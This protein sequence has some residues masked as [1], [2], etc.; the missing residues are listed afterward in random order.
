MNTG[1]RAASGAMIAS[2]DDDA[3]PEPD[4]LD[5]AIAG[6][7]RFNC[8]YVG[9]KVLPIWGGPVPEWLPNRPGMLWS[10]V[11][12]LDFGP[13]AAEFGRDG[14]TW[15]L[16]IN[17]LARREAFQRVGPYDNRLGRTAGTLRNQAQREWHLR[18]RQSGLRGFYVPDMVVHHVVPAERLQKRYF[19]RWLYW[20]GIS[21]AILY[22]I[23]SVDMTGPENS[24][25]DFKSV[26]HIFGVPRYMFRSTLLRP[27]MLTV[28]AR[29]RRDP[30]TAFENELWLWF[31]A[32]VL[33]H[34]L[35]DSRKRRWATS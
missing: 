27:L 18:A 4:W 16:G 8:D 9:G 23:A 13:T 24:S 22:D 25:L 1:I 12:L 26:P 34:C 2:T 3:R 29:A 20:H 33:K 7:E 21:R 11:A 17:M 31:F 14:M 5:R 35:L 19:R 28:T 32:G 30:V 15:P 10:P 6:L